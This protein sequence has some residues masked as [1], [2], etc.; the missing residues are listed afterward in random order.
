MFDTRSEA[1]E[2]AGLAVEVTERSA[3]RARRE[4]LALLPVLVGMMV[5]YSLRKQLFGASADTPVRIATVLALF[6]LGWTIARDI[7]RAAA[8]T[9]FRRMDPATAGTVGF[10]I[11]LGTIAITL[12]V[13]LRIANVSPSTVLAGSAFTAVI[14]GLAAQQTLGNWLA[15][16]LQSR[17]TSNPSVLRWREFSAVDGAVASFGSCLLLV[18]ALS[19]AAVSRRKERSGSERPQTSPPNRSCAPWRYAGWLRIIRR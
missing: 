16:L 13:A 4:A 6:G 7:G 3:T 9:F 14:L 1:W 12:L 18:R 15:G 10:L 11:R 5:V 8:P 17:V 2:A 19:M